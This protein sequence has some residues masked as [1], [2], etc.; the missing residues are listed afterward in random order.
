MEP[1]E[2]RGG[3]WAS[4]RVGEWASGRVGEWESGRVGEGEWARGRGGVGFSFN[5]EPTATASRNTMKNAKP[6]M[7][8]AK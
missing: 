4:G 6:R 3:E 2:E 5:P 7:Q 1:R 8:N